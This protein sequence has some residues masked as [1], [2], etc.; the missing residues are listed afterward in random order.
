MQDLKRLNPDFSSVDS[1]EYQISYLSSE[2]A[3]K[4]FANLS[5]CFPDSIRCLLISEKVPVHGKRL[6]T[7]KY[8]VAQKK[9][10]TMQ[11]VNIS[12]VNCCS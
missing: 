9:W 12:Y 5:G 2:V 10:T 7:V 11:S 6:Y 4:S 1:K 3:L 8:R